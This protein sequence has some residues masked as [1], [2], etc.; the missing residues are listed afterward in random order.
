MRTF[1]LKMLH[2]RTLCVQYLMMTFSPSLVVGL[3]QPCGE[4]LLPDRR[5]RSG[6]QTR[7]TAVPVVL[8][9]LTA[10][11]RQER[12][13]F[14]LT[15]ARATWRRPVKW[16]ISLR[17]KSESRWQLRSGFYANH[18]LDM[19]CNRRPAASYPCRIPSLPALSTRPTDTGVRTYSQVTR[20]V[21]ERYGGYRM[22]QLGNPLPPTADRST[23]EMIS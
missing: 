16:R 21:E 20:L 12:Q 4:V 17:G 8:R 2:G 14:R 10:E 3:L 15:I 19:S 5:R 9:P 18:K 7:C 22:K 23:S 1:T 13:T 11:T 6:K